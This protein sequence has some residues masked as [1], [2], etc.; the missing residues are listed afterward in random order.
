M[1]RPSADDIGEWMKF[2]ISF[3]IPSSDTMFLGASLAAAPSSRR[4][5]QEPSAF[6]TPR[7]PIGL[8]LRWQDNVSP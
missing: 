2:G 5:F 1:F 7:Q 3:Y 8:V 4:R 6:L